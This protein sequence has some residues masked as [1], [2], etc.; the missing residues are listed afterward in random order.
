MRLRRNDSASAV[1]ATPLPREARP[2]RVAKATQP[3][4]AFRVT[5]PVDLATAAYLFLTTLALL[6]PGRPAVWPSILLAHLLAGAALLA[7]A[8]R[9]VAREPPFVAHAHFWYP[10]VLVPFLYAELP[11][12]NQ[13]FGRGYHDAL[14]GGIDQA[15]FG[16]EPARHLAALLPFGPL[17]EFLHLSYLS[18]YPLV[19]LPPLI[20]YLRGR[21]RAAG[22]TV[23]AVVTT[24]FVCY[25][26]FVFFPVQGP[27]YLWTAPAGVPPGPVR[28]LALRILESA[29]SRG[30]AF[31]SS[32]AAVTVAQTAVAA[33]LQ[34]RLFP[35]LALFTTGL[36]VG[37]VYGG[38]HYATD[39]IVGAA[40][41]L[42]TAAFVRRAYPLLARAS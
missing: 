11:L 3:R 42:A 41:G 17:S 6:G 9:D 38:F 10:V 26:W 33:R 23:F 2:A 21:R 31:P 37:A 30:A 16:F 35:V 18:Y 32:H 12:L 8:L 22:E 40:V 24:F 29:S 34:P 4:G 28:E 7:L 19:L 27:R 39:M 20:V 1:P 15:L 36:L 14:I 13:S 5:R 25:V